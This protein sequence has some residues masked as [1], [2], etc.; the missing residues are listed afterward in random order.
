MQP[1]LAKDAKATATIQAGEYDPFEIT[2]R[3]PTGGEVADVL[4]ATG[5]TIT[6][7]NAEVPLSAIVGRESR[8]WMAKHLI[9]WTLPIPPTFDS[10]DGAIAAPEILA[11]M[12]TAMTSADR[13]GEAEKN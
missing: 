12:F 3:I 1:Y 11:E 5:A 9:S 6:G 8:K 4:S 13:R 7:G 2:F 10:I